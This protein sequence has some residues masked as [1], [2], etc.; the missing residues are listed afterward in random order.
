MFT[1]NH[2]KKNMLEHLS[3]SI[4]KLSNDR[5]SLQGSSDFWKASGIEAIS[6]YRFSMK[7]LSQ[8][9][10]EIKYLVWSITVLIRGSA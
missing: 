8:F 2:N 6:Y 5:S 1:C 3:P 7:R 10:E 4:C 9:T